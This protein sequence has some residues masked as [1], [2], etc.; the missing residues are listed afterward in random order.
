MADITRSEHVKRT[1]IAALIVAGIVGTVGYFWQDIA[2]GV[3]SAFAW[4]GDPVS[5][6]RWLYG[7][8]LGVA[9]GVAAVLVAAVIV[10][11]RRPEHA[12]YVEDVFF[13]FVWR[14]KWNVRGQVEDLQWYCANCDRIGVYDYD[15]FEQVAT[16]FCSQCRQ[17]V[18]RPGTRN[19]MLNAVLREINLKVRNGQWKDVVEAQKTA[20]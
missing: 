13:G 17:P 12:A 5:V 9:G 18:R 15:R 8:L 6:P 7:L 14:W 2:G 3:G 10:G 1:V 16:F 4:L 20:A 19:E 11:T